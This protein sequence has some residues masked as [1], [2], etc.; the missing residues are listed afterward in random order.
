[1]TDIFCKYRTLHSGVSASLL[2][3][4]VGLM[5]KGSIVQVSQEGRTGSSLVP[6]LGTSAL[7]TA[8]MGSRALKSGKVGPVPAFSRFTLYGACNK[9]HLLFEDISANL[10]PPPP[11]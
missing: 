6:A 4:S 2:M 3:S 5:Y 1:M 8:A 7:L 9:I 11:P 10:A